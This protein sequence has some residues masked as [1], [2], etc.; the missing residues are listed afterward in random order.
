MTTTSVGGE[1]QIS[2]SA[3]SQFHVIQLMRY[4]HLY[5]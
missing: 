5:R 1:Q 3:G 2:I 4:P